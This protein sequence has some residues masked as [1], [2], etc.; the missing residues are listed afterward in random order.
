[1]FSYLFLWSTGTT[2]LFYKLLCFLFYSEFGILTVYNIITTTTLRSLH[3]PPLSINC[4]LLPTHIFVL[5]YWM[6]KKNQEKNTYVPNG[7]LRIRDNNQLK[8]PPKL[9]RNVHHLVICHNLTSGKTIPCQCQRTSTIAWPT[10]L[11]RVDS[12]LP[13]RLICRTRN[14]SGMDMEI[15]YF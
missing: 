15:L 8:L 1:M 14:K 3:R 7:S 9:K 2:T 13:Q 11:P 12:Q 6:D 4:Y 5:D 10:S